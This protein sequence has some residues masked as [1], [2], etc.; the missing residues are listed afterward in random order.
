MF[1]YSLKE[2]GLALTLHLSEVS[3]V[4]KVE[5]WVRGLKKN[6]SM[7]DSR[8]LKNTELIT[9]CGSIVVFRL[10]LG[11]KTGWYSTEKQF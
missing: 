7:T 4:V 9:Q 1:P 8:R 3:L 2:A 11:T 6:K 5:S 10:K